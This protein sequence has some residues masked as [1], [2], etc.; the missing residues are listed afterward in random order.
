MCRRV[1]PP[2]TMPRF[3]IIQPRDEVRQFRKVGRHG[4]RIIRVRKHLA[5]FYDVRREFRYPE[6]R[7]AAGRM[8]RIDREIA[9]PIVQKKLCCP[10]ASELE[11][12]SFAETR[13][14]IRRH[15]EDI[16]RPCRRQLCL[17]HVRKRPATANLI[18][19][20]HYPFSC[21]C[22]WQ[23]EHQDAQRED[24][25]QTVFGDMSIS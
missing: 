21:A 2:E 25:V 18:S 17:V 20:S 22:F 5:Q 23:Q 19:A 4:G 9:S 8:R 12:F 7:R 24:F 14:G 1:R 16:P 3:T 15:V 6:D 13:D 10:E 11:A